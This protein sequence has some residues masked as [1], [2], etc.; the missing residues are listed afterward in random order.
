MSKKGGGGALLPY[1]SNFS[2]TAAGGVSKMELGNLRWETAKFNE[3]LQVYELGLGNSPTDA[4]LLE[5]ELR[6]R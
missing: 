3:R 1:A 4:S 2:Y 6:I 5:D